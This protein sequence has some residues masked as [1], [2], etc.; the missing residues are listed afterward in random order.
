MLLGA[1]RSTEEHNVRLRPVDSIVDPASAAQHKT[2]TWRYKI[3]LRV[4]QYGKARF[5][6]RV[7]GKLH[8]Y[9]SFSCRL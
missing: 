2:M 7:K 3:K 8:K 1:E 5:N 9:V 4:V 6:N